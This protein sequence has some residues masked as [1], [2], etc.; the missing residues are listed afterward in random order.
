MQN[1]F[2]ETFDGRMRDRLLN[3]GLFCTFDNNKTW[4]GSELCEEPTRSKTDLKQASVVLLINAIVDD[5]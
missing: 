5:E 2:V 4:V 3:E 1:S